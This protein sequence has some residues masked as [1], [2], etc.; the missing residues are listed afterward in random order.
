MRREL[1]VAQRLGFEHVWLEGA[2]L[3]EHIRCDAFR[4]GL[5]GPRP[6]VANPAKL[7]RGLKDV[8]DRLDVPI[9]EQTP[10][11]QLVD[12]EPLTLRTPNGSVK[13]GRVVIGLNGYSGALGFQTS[14]VLDAA[15]T[16][17][18]PATELEPI[19]PFPGFCT[20]GS[21]TLPRSEPDGGRSGT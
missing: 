13:A 21:E 17:F 2:A 6:F 15:H 14:T 3:D 5:Y 16:S 4:S 18:S 19:N 1:D 8:V 12:G 9:Y 10:L 11:V 7:A 20:G